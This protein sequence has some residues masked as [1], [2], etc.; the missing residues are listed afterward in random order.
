MKGDI[1]YI[2]IT[3]FVERTAEELDPI[4]TSV[5]ASAAG[6]VLDLRGNPGG[7]LATVVD[8]G[9]FFLE[10][11]KLMA[12]VVDN[13]GKR[14]PSYVGSKRT[15]ADLPMVVADRSWQRQRQRGTHRRPPRLRRA[16]VAGAISFGKGSVN[17]LR[18]LSDG[19]GIYITTARWLTPKGRLIEGKGITPDQPLSPE[20]DAVQWAI[21]FLKGD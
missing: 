9:G 6:I 1:A 11:G 16:T 15:A 5:R 17:I 19:S 10:P 7:Y 4:M 18:Q 12:D 20:Q 3:Q 8:V 13:K 14:T 2:K 21:D